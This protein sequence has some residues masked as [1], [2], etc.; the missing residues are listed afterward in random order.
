MHEL[1]SEGRAMQAQLA[2]LQVRFRDLDCIAKVVTAKCSVAGVAGN[3]VPA[4]VT[5]QLGVSCAELLAACG[6]TRDVQ[7]S[8]DF[9]SMRRTGLQCCWTGWSSGVCSCPRRTACRCCGRLALLCWSA[10]AQPQQQRV[11]SAALWPPQSLRKRSSSSSRQARLHRLGNQ[12]RQRWRRAA[13][14]QR[15]CP[16]SPPLSQRLLVRQ[17]RQT[18]QQQSQRS[19]QQAAARQHS[20]QPPPPSQLLLPMLVGQ[21]RQTSQQPSLRPRQQAAR[22]RRR[23]CPSQ[24]LRTAL[25]QWWCRSPRA[26]RQAATARQ[27]QRLLQQCAQVPR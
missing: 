9:L 7:A 24:L 1:R 22:Q 3:A 19:R 25:R 18:S 8:L 14:S 17:R 2:S 11:A 15:W 12:P 21:R 13:Q 23:Q 4:D 5:E 26:L 6:Q 16:L 20:P 27:P 10:L